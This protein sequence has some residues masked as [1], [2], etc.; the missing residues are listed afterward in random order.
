MRHQTRLTLFATLALCGSGLPGVS[1][2]EA[3]PMPD[4]PADSSLP[5][6]TPA[7]PQLIPTPTLGGSQFWGDVAVRGGWR[8]Q[9]QVFTGTHR[10]LDANQ[11]QHATGTKERC[12]AVLNSDAV[13]AVNPPMT[14]EITL[15]VHGILR[16]SNSMGRLGKRLGRAGLQPQRFDYPSTQTT[17]EEA[18]ACL[19]EA[20]D[21]L[22]PGV[23][24][25]NFVVHSMGGLVVRAYGKLLA[26][27]LA[28]GDTRQPPLGRLVM[29]ATPNH[30]AEMAS[31]LKNFGPFQ[32]MFGPAGRQL[33]HNESLVAELPVP[34]C[35]FA[36]IAGIRGTPKGFNPFIP[37]DDDGTVTLASARLSGASDFLAVKGLHSFLLYQNEVVDSVERYLQTG[38]LRA[39]GV[40]EPIK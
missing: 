11:L 40:R 25:V 15:L 35:E 30:G 22:D 2:C 33:A 19:A 37:G 14:G 39:S 29:I 9:R 32:A 20:I 18:A 3:D 4:L 28:D 17:I 5:S 13:L 1:R 8:V 12:V 36:V 6:D 27:R 24:R 34:P 16:G 31:H 7:D 10:L 23:T 26:Q 38:T 21:G